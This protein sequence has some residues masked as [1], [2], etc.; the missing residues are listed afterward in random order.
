MDVMFKSIVLY[1]SVLTKYD[2]KHVH[3]RE[4]QNLILHQNL[5]ILLLWTRGLISVPLLLFM[6]TATEA[7]F[8]A[9]A[10]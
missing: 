5:E 8:G 3:Q 9:A 10:S 6:C 2:N 7:K 1:L 4:K